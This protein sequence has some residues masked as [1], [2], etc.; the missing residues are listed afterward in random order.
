MSFYAL[1]YLEYINQYEMPK[2]LSTYVKY[3]GQLH[4]VS[5]YL[6][7]CVSIL[8]KIDNKHTVEFR[9]VRHVMGHGGYMTRHIYVN[10]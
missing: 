2:Y 8:C 4:M 6:A 9:I 3:S 7:Y 5:A 1:T 10:I